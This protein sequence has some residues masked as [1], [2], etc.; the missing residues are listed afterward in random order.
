MGFFAL[1][2]CSLLPGFRVTTFHFQFLND[3]KIKQFRLILGNFFILCHIRARHI[4]PHLTRIIVNAQGVNTSILVYCR[5]PGKRKYKKKLTQ[6]QRD[7]FRNIL[8]KINRNLTLKQVLMCPCLNIEIQRNFQK[9][10]FQWN[11]FSHRK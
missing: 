4:T 7:L 10:L 9:L 3:V 6:T 2:C 1:Q 11:D 8:M 5:S